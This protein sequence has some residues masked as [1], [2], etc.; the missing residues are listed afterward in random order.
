MRILGIDTATP[1]AS[2]AVVDG[3]RPA[4]LRVAPRDETSDSL[5]D[6]VEGALA[7]AGASLDALDG[8]AVAV[9]PGSFTGLRTGIAAVQGLLFGAAGPP[10]VGVSTLEAMAHTAETAGRTVVPVLDARRDAVFGAVFAGGRRVVDDGVFDPDRLAARAGED[11]LFLAP[12]EAAPRARSG[13][14][15]LRARLDLRWIDPPT[16]GRTAVEVARL[17]A[18]ALSRGEGAPAARLRPR[19]LRESEA[20]IGVTRRAAAGGLVMRPI[21]PEDLDR[22]LA[23]ETDAY[24]RPWSRRMFEEELA[25]PTTVSVAAE[26]GG[27]VVGYA[28]G[29]VLLDDLHV[30]N[31]AVAPACQRRGLGEAVLRSL[32]RAAAAA[33]ARRATLE[34]RPSN[35]AALGL[36]RRLGFRE[37]GRRPGYYE[38][39]EDALLLWLESVPVE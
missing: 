31:V 16:A 38:N 9:G 14:A 27:E 26:E 11:A 37:V 36:Y 3:D 34:V 13:L 4:A 15:R 21:R 10:T 32:F 7:E 1:R 39:G 17:G 18:L 20:E 12:P 28:F 6:L 22:I 24:P 35:A 23:V 19:Y 25:N 29:W 30:N 2:V 5:L 33:G 8:V